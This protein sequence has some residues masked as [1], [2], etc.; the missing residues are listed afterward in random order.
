MRVLVVD[1]D[2]DFREVLGFALERSGHAVDTAADGIAA[3]ARL[4]AEPPDLILLDLELPGLAGEDVAAAFRRTPGWAAVP[5]ALISGREDVA[6]VAA[7]LGVAYVQ[8]PVRLAAARH[9]VDAL[10]VRPPRV[11]VEGS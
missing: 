7:R 4:R 6:E 8:K 9:L 11:A 10:A 1:D 3:L 5:I 2:A